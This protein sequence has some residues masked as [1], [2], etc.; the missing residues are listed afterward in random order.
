MRYSER[1]TDTTRDTLDTMGNSGM[2][3]LPMQQIPKS[4]ETPQ[5]LSKLNSTFDLMDFGRLICNNKTV[6]FESE[7]FDQ[8]DKRLSRLRSTKF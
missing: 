4:S 7:L 5:L 6:L 2:S 3:P 1:T 8:G